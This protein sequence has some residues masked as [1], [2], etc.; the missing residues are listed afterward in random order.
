M[1]YV[2]VL[3]QKR[4][5]ILRAAPEPAI[6]AASEG[7]GPAPRRKLAALLCAD[8]AGFSRL[9]GADESGTYEALSRL[10]AAIDPVVARRGGR[11]VSTAGDG[12]L[13][14]FPSVV[15]ALACAV[16]IQEC[17]G[18]LNAGLAD[19]R[20]LELRIG[21]NL[22]DVIVAAD[23]DLYGDGVNIAARLQALAPPGRI[24]LSQI[25]CEQVRNKLDLRFRPLG[26]HRVKNIAE[27]VRVYAVEGAANVPGS[28][29]PPARRRRWLIGAAL[30]A[31]LA[32]AAI[33]ALLGFQGRLPRLPVPGA[34][35]EAASVATL[36]MPAR[37]AE[38]TTVAVLPF[39]DL[40]PEPGQEFFSDGVTE[41]IINALG[42][43]SNLLVSAKSASFQFKGKNASPE[44]IGRALG[45]RY[46]VEGSIRRA[47]D[48]L[49]LAVGLTEAFTGSHLWSDTYDTELKEVFAV[50]DRIVERIVGAT[51]VRLTRIERD[52]A[53]RKPTANFSAYEYFLRGRSEV[54]N[55]TRQA[56]YEARAQFERAI[57][58]DPNFAAAYAALG[59]A[60]FEAAAAGWSEFRG[61]EVR[62]AEELANK[63]LL[64]DANDT[65]ALRLLSS[66]GVYRHDYRRAQ[67][68]ID[69]A[70]AVNPSD[71]ENFLQ[72]GYILMF[73]G[74]PA[75]AVSWLEA[76]V[77]IDA[78]SARA[79]IILGIA[80]FFL[81]RYQEAIAAVEQGLQ[82]GAGRA[83]QLSGRPVL[84]A[85]HARLGHERDAERERDA[86]MRLSPFFDAEQYTAQFGT[87]EARR[88]MI[89]GLREAGFK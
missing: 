43:F 81:G 86:V 56:N 46:L 58:L 11:I 68:D 21:V 14:D 37:M 55:P 82:H 18:D 31:G 2:R 72:R 6:E 30:G 34:I 57:A 60:R 51:A 88:D 35:V 16:E 83:V 19:G 67:A 27:P 38:R 9:M 8:V 66:I 76:A 59:W 70:L 75:E 79:P 22:G 15:D 42:R 33:A 69:R 39:R 63:A 47:G 54:W 10:R 40:S 61:D 29:P 36:A 64:L 12:L 89:T 71:A 7:T 84:A 17:A 13:A 77:R 78:T 48:R 80:K 45:V 1:V 74:Q 62:A 28:R 4:R 50:Q 87:E 49:R 65:T 52:R 53:A 25:V 3:D 5:G 85:A 20:R 23:G 24:C 32:L 26:V 44:E 41:D 73:A